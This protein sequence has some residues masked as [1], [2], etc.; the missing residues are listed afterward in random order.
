M[1][2]I[3]KDKDSGMWYVH[4]RGYP[5]VPCFGTFTEKKSEAVEYCKMYNNK[6]HKANLIEKRKQKEV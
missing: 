6:P 2:V 5:H 4:A 1:Y 3:S